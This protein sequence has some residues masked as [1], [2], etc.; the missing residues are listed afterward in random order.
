MSDGKRQHSDTE[1]EWVG[2]L[3]SEAVPIKKK[4]G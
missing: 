3:P 4:R 2:P 1:D